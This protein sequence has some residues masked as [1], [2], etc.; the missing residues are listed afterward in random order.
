MPDLE[1]YLTVFSIT[2]L[3]LMLYDIFI[4]TYI[5]KQMVCE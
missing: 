4:I 2:R 5:K 3:V 1:L